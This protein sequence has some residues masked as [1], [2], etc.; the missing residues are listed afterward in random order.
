MQQAGVRNV[1]LYENKDLAFTFNGGQ[2]ATITTQGRVINIDYSQRGDFSFTTNNNNNAKVSYSYLLKWVIFEYT[3]TSISDIKLIKESIYGWC[4][5]VFFDDGTAKFYKIPFKSPTESEIQIQKS[6]HFPVEVKNIIGT[7]ITGHAFY[8]PANETEEVCYTFD[9]SLL[10][11][12]TRSNTW[13]YSCS[14]GVL[15]SSD[16]RT[17]DGMHFAGSPAGWSSSIQDDQG[18]LVTANHTGTR[19]WVQMFIESIPY[20]DVGSYQIEVDTIAL[21]AGT[22]FYCWYGPSGAENL[23][24]IGH[25]DFTIVITE[26]SLFGFEIAKW[27]DPGTA[28]IDNLVIRKL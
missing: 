20:L 1:I 27:D 6:M 7:Q 14:G 9:T 16:F 24:A 15:F 5:L 2:I 23:N 21:S 28:L 12:D 4:P 8:I 13:D 26:P 22:V 3:E 10:T 18:K 11:W 17:L 25:H 19:N